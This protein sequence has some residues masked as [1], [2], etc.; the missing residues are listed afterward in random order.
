[1]LNKY[2]VQLMALGIVGSFAATAVAED[3]ALI[4]ALVKKGVLKSKE[5][6]QIR[7]EAAKGSHSSSSKLN[8]DSS[9]KSLALSGDFRVRYNYTSGTGANPTQGGQP[10]APRPA[11]SDNHTQQQSFYDFRLR[12]NADYTISDDFYAGFGLRTQRDARNDNALMGSNSADLGIGIYRAFLGWNPVEGVSLVAGKQKNPF[13]TTDLVWDADLNPTG[14]SQKVD[15]NKTFGFSGIDL[16]LVSGQFVMNDN[17][18]SL[19]NQNTNRDSFLWQTQLVAGI[20]LGGAKLTIAPGYLSTNGANSN[21]LNPPTAPFTPAVQVGNYSN[22]VQVLLVPGDIS[23]EVAGI[24]TKFEWDF[25]YNFAGRD[26]AQFS[27]PAIAAN[28]SRSA[29]KLAWLLGVRLGENKKKGDWSVLAN[30]RQTGAGAL[31]YLMSDNEFAFGDT[32]NMSGFKVGTAYS[33]SDSAYFGVNYL[34]FEQ[35]R[36]Q[37]DQRGVGFA[38]GEWLQAEVGV[39]F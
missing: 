6:E 33:V 29:D 28:N 25:A 36:S 20:D 10:V 17:D 1:M 13:Y 30:Y 31:P 14:F 23:G 22:D 4:D 21:T 5:A 2:T 19:A 34:K 39:K 15:L 3:S 27:T 18:E 26:R 9:V 12:I 11:G 24:K 16:S 37:G 8:L 35:T 38:V 7:A 32:R